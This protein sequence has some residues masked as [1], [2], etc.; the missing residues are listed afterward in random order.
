MPPTTSLIW[1]YFNKNIGK[2]Y[3]LPE[4][5]SDMGHEAD[6]SGPT[7]IEET[8]QIPTKVQQSKKQRMKDSQT[9]SRW[10]KKIY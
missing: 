8:P 5:E 2:Y 1:D 10:L 3:L 7:L 6:L 4:S 9:S